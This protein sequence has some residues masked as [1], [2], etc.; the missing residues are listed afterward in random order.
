MPELTKFTKVG[1]PLTKQISLAKDGT[2]VSDGSACVMSDGSAE[3]VKV[4]GV[5]ELA[6]LIG[7]LRPSQAIALGALRDGLP[8]KV[9]IVSEKQLNGVARPDIIARSGANIVY[10]GL[11][12]ALLDYDTKGMP[13]DVAAEL[14]RRG[15]FWDAVLTVLPALKDTAHVT[16]HSTSAGLSRADTGEALA[17]SDGMHVY[18]AAK[19]GSDSERFLRALHD[20]CWLAG[21]GWF[22][23][24]AS[25][26][27]LERSIVDRMVGGAERLVFEGGPVL[28]P[29]LRQDKASRRPI[30]V[31]GEVLDTGTVCPPLNIVETERLEGLKARAAQRLA[32][33]VAKAKAAFIERQAKKIVKRTGLSEQAACKIIERQCEGVLHPNIEL[34]FDD[35]KL[36]DKTVG[37][38]LANPDRFEGETLADPLEGVDYGPCKAKVMRRADGTPWIHSFAHGRTTYELK[39][40]AASVCKAMEKAAK[41]EV[42]TTF[43]KLMLSADVDAVEIEA[44]RQLAKQLS[45]V[46]LRVIDSALKAAQQM[47]TEQR[48]K[49]A[50]SRRTAERR[51]P[52]PHI[53]APFPDEPFNPQMDVLN[54]VIGKV[55]AAVPPLRNIDGVVAHPSKRPVPFT[56]ANPEGDDK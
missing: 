45:G 25:G 6:A 28:V 23:V 7:K 34:P 32:P 44:L 38:V 3:R 55:V 13:T 30:A 31:E 37:D 50:R 12:F 54:E 21:L 18:V 17:G 46:G 35:P 41:E 11:A 26:A 53:K 9:Q 33:D 16:R 39:H 29:P 1:G 4:A 47:H 43:A 22:V 48:T 56:D 27:L 49:E 51:D 40:D 20:R 5:G 24:S 52:R 8:D 10:R 42:V 19:D 15:G 2:I 36:A 14:K